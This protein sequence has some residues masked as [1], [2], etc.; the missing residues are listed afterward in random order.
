[1]C[2][3]K[4]QKKMNKKYILIEY[5]VDFW[6]RFKIYMGLYFNS[7]LFQLLFKKKQILSKIS[8]KTLRIAN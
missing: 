3:D 8:T 5:N 6:K 1:M 7:F 2:G 4:E